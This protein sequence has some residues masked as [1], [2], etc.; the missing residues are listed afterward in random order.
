MPL[1]ITLQPPPSV[2][3]SVAPTLSFDGACE[4]TDNTKTKKKR[5]IRLVETTRTFVMSRISI[6]NGDGKKSDK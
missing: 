5:K 6:T 3:A 4:K 1:W 2:I